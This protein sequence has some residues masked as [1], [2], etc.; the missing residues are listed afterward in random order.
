MS[1]VSW[2]EIQKNSPG[3]NIPVSNTPSSQSPSEISDTPKNPSFFAKLANLYTVIGAFLL[4]TGLALIV[5]PAFPYLY[6]NINVQATEDEV[7]TLSQLVTTTRRATA[8]SPTPSLI[9]TPTP[10]PLP[11]KNANLP[12]KNTLFINGIGVN[13][14]INEGADS[15]RALYKGIWRH[16]EWGT[17]LDTDI[18][19]IIAAHRFG[20]IEWSAEFRKTNSF[21]NLPS[22]KAGDTFSVIWDQREFV[23]QVKRVEEAE[24][25]YTRDSEMILYTCKHLKSPIR[26]IVYADRVR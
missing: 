13:G 6:Y 23:Y 14:P 21:S 19:T 24:S 1:T 5:I 15:K 26:I 7:E 4:I 3:Q 12:A 2:S 22:M 9:T 25:V 18:P 8:I 20:Y 10:L 16:P 11:P 17:P